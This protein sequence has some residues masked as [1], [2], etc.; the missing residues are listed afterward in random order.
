LVLAGVLVGALALAGVSL[1]GC[2]SAGSLQEATQGTTIPGSL[3]DV[4]VVSGIGKVTTPPDEA[5][6]QASVESDG[7]T[8]AAA[9]D[10]NS[11]K[12][13]KVLDRLKAEGIADKDIATANVT[14]YPNTY[15]DPQTGEQKT[16][17]YRAS[18]MVTVTFHDLTIVGKVFAA[19]TEAG[20]DSVYGPN[21]QLSEDSAAVATALTKAIANARM[22]AEAIAA[23]QGIQLGE[24]LIIS[25]GSGAS[26]YPMY[27]A[28]AVPAGADSSVTPPPLSPQ[29]IDVTATVTVTYRM[30]R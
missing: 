30:V 25:E 27:E 20:A 5:T 14:V 4:I 10:A 12:T 15:Y 29:N 11:K 24:A 13:Q 2:G 17:G 28:R 3:V 8:S 1:A 16:T 7:A 18:N 26:V 6:I 21:W 19:V 9:L 22:K 23:D